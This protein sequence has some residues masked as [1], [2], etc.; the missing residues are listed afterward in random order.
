MLSKSD[1]VSY[2]FNLSTI[3]VEEVDIYDLKA[4]P[5]NTANSKPGWDAQ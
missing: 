2:K 5:V 1:V 4:G 3:E